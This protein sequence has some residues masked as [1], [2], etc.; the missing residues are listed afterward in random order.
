[1]A[2]QEA[3]RPLLPQAAAVRATCGVRGNL[4]RVISAAKPWVAPKKPLLA[5]VTPVCTLSDDLQL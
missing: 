2:A 1:M 4:R 5:S 3:T